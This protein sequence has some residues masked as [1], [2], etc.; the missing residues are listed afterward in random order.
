MLGLGF[1]YIKKPLGTA[2]GSRMMGLES[3]GTGSA[4][5]STIE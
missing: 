3:Q 4:P 1:E 2:A 5:K